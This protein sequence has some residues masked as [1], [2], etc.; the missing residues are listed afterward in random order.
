M[1]DN[2]ERHEKYYPLGLDQISRV[3]ESVFKN[4]KVDSFNL[5]GTGFRNSNYMI[6]L[7]DFSEPLVLRLYKGG[8][9]TAGKEMSISRLV[10]KTVPT[11]DYIH[12]DTSSRLLDIPWAILEWKP[13]TA[14]SEL[15]KI[16][17]SS[18]IASYANPVGRTLAE[19]HKYKFSEHGF[20]GPSL[21]VVT[22]FRL[23]E[24]HFLQLTGKFLNERCGEFLG[25]TIR[26]SLWK[27]CIKN[28]YALME[29]EEEPALVH[30]DYNGL[31]ILIEGDAPDV[32]VSAVLDWEFAF[33]GS[34]YADIGNLLRYEE[35]GSAFERHFIKGYR[36]GG[37]FLDPNWRML[38]KLQDL[39]ALC[40]LL[41]RS[42]TEAPRRVEDI[43]S[44]ITRTLTE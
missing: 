44:L 10:R 38:A 23:D 41:N 34:R 39:V 19:I 26:D 28:S 6:F 25:H 14:L 2:W 22:P 17:D 33:S 40:D 20:L 30:S 15:M 16:G 3:I 32:S 43:R 9:D 27:F 8:K 5:L 13:G 12:V 18:D 1:K 29:N 42:T 37:C 4:S 21:E 35:E 24:T 11:A 7:E 36:E 31:N